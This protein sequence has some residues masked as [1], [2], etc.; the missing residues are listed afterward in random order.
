MPGAG[1]IPDGWNCAETTK[2]DLDGNGWPDVFVIFARTA[3]ASGDP[4]LAR[5]VLTGGPTY[6]IGFTA[7]V[8]EARSMIR[9]HVDVDRDGRD[10]VLVELG[11][12]AS[13]EIVGV[14][15]L[16]KN[17]LVQAAY[18]DGTKAR[19]LF[20]GSVRHG[21]AVECRSQSGRAEL[22]MRGISNYTADDQWDWSESV[23]TWSSKVLVLS[24][25]RKGVIK[26]PHPFDPPP[27]EDAFWSFRCFGVDLY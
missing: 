4:W 26:V 21:A 16:G 25:Q 9:G 6:E 14:F 5:I 23:Y 18:Q 7:D 24:S 10:D 1:P 11:H 2:V 27:N 20:A 19:L 13:T 3:P 17:G 8:D 12:G 15:G 22:V